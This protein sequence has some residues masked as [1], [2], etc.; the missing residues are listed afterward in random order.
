MKHTIIITALVLLGSCKKDDD[1]TSP[2][3]YSYIRVTRSD[4]A[5]DV[6][7]ERNYQPATLHWYGPMTAANHAVYTGD[8]LSLSLSMDTVMV[9]TED[10]TVEIRHE[11]SVVATWY[12][13]AGDTV[14]PSSF[15]MMVP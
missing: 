11:D 13:Q 7:F 1:N 8:H 5:V 10:L 6:R 15:E 4:T 14:Q 9:P 2:G 3:R 12:T